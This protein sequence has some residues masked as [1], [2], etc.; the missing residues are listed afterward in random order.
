[1]CETS[2]ESEPYAASLC[3]FSECKAKVEAIRRT[4]IQ[5]LPPVLIIHLKR[6]EFNLESMTKFKVN[7]RC[8][9][10]MVLDMQRFTTDWLYEEEEA[11]RENS[12]AA[13]RGSMLL[14][15]TGASRETGE[16]EF[17]LS[18]RG[19]SQSLSQSHVESE[20]GGGG[21]PSPFQYQLRG[22]VAHVGTADSGHYYR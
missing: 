20:A 8:S 18:G 1:M 6:F 3:P 21:S 7:D 22:V 17:G 13:S 12:I 11:Q 9:F 5:K 15:T 4:A 10:P 16:G 14:D 2:S 19:L